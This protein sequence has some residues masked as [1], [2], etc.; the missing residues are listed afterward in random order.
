MQYETMGYLPEAMVNFLARLGWSH[1]DSEIFTRDE[2]KE[3]FDLEHISPSP[4]RF[5]TDKLKWVNQEHMKRL[6]QHELGRQLEPYLERAGYPRA[7]PDPGDV[8]MLLRDRAATLA[9]MAAAAHYFYAAPAP[10]P[11]LARGQLN[12]TNRAALLDLIVL[13]E[14]LDWTREAIAAAVKGAAARH[15]L[16]PP[17]VMMPLRILVCGTR[18]TPAIDAVLALIGRDATRARLAT[19]LAVMA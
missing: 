14:T 18:E 2:L 5:D 1:G 3:W 7:G 15:G 8:A 9:D 11:E 6:S 16:K 4:S 13:F 10:S 12:D 17:Q 19:S